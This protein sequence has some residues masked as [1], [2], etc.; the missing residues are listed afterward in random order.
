[1]IRGHCRTNLD[2]F[3]RE[4][5]P[6]IFPDNIEIGWEI[7][8]KSGRVLKVSSITCT[9]NKLQDPSLN[10]MGRYGPRYSD[11]PYIIVEL[12]R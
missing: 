7:K 8:G 12:S 10:N 11:E 4:I 6:E 5:W 1:M 2:D 3:H 9:T